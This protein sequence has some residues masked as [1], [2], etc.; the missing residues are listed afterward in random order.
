MNR[1]YYIDNLRILCILLLFPFHAAM[2]FNSF[3]D[4]F[5]VHG[6]SSMALSSI[7]IVTFPW[8]MALL[9]VISGMSSAYAMKSRSLK[10]YLK[11]RV[12]R[13]FVPL[14]FG[15]MLVIPAQTYIADIWNNGYTGGYFEHYKVFFTRLTD[16]SGN[17]GCFTPGN[18]WFILYLFV[19]SVLF[20][21][22]FYWYKNSNHKIKTQKLNIIMIALLVIPLSL[23]S[24]L[25]DIGGK[26]IGDYGFCFLIGFFIIAEENVQKLLKKYWLP[27]TVIWLVFMAVRVLMWC[28]DVK[29]DII[30]YLN[31]HFFEWSGILACLGLGR[32]FLSAKTKLTEYFTKASFPMYVIHQTILVATA[33]FMIKWFDIVAVSY[34][35]I[36]F[37]SLVLTVFVYEIFKRISVFRFMFGIK[38]NIKES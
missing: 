1:K 34:V 20:A 16:W 13:L 25:G 6:N 33:Y 26:S 5:Y 38:N 31:Y 37:V 2:C 23:I 27:L 7:I 9:F 35:L 17:D 29:G 12:L 30:W 11:E 3:G 36:V 32:K 19:F 15:L 18:L 28:N 24:R 22:L 4:G 8:W 21:P 10:Q 14:I